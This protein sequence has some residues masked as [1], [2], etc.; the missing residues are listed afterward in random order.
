V[1]DDVW[2][3]PVKE[4]CPGDIG[5]KWRIE[6]LNGLAIGDIG[7]CKNPYTTP[8]TIRFAAKGDAQFHQPVWTESWFPDA[9]AGTMGQLLIALETATVPAISGSDNLLTIALV[10]AAALSAAE[11]RAVSPQEIFSPNRKLPQNP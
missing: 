1:I 3:G 6:G 9:F 11:R 10:E 2:T 4:G 8:S 5:I 7:W